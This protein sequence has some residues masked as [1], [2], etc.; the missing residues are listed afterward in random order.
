[1]TVNSG[2]TLGGTGNL[3]S[4]TVNAGGNLAPGDSLGTLSVS[5]SLI[6]SAGAVMDYELD[7]PST[8]SM[9][10]AGSLALNG[11]QFTDFNF[12]WSGNFGQGTYPLIAFLSTQRQ[13]GSEYKRHDRRLPGNARR[14]RQRPGGYR[15]PRNRSTAAL[16]AAG[17][18]GLIG[19]AWRKRLRNSKG[20]Y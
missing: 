17:V 8:S 14:A 18:L 2:G 12:T 13:S 16:L 3:A 11:Q 1:M 4:V 10:N 9:I 20:T 15:R 5:G 6:L 7:T 19:R